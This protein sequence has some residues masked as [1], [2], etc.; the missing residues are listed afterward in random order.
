MP[1]SL[2]EATDV[3]SLQQSQA[4]LVQALEQAL[5]VE[6]V[7]LEAVDMAIRLHHFLLLEVD[8]QAVA[9]GAVHSAEQTVD[10]RL[11]K[12]DGQQAVLEAVAVEDLSE[13][14]R[15]DRADTPVG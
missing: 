9:G 8:T 13:A 14:R 1:A 3:L 12:D 7:D 4:D 6:A 11:V 5:L 15:D 10:G 2:F